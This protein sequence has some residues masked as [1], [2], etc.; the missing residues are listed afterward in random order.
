MVKTTVYLPDHEVAALRRL[1]TQTGRSQAEIIRQ[2]VAAVTARAAPREF[3]S[4][5]A[6]RGDGT[7][8]ARH[9][10]EILRREFPRDDR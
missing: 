7:P 6:G 5:G 4:F 1:S 8:V 3:L 2:A 9:A 10:D